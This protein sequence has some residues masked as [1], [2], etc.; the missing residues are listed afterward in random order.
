V[1]SKRVSLSHPVGYERAGFWIRFT[2]QWID[3]AIVI[4]LLTLVRRVLVCVDLYLPFELSFIL[5]L[6]LYNV[7]LVAWSGATLGKASCGLSVRQVDDEDLGFWRVLARETL[8]KF[9]SFAAL[10]LGYLWVGITRRKRSWHDILTSTAVFRHV[11][12]KKRGQRLTAAV[13]ALTTLALSVYV[14]QVAGIYILLKQMSHPKDSKLAY[15]EREPTNLTEVSSIEPEGQVEFLDWIASHGENPV[16]YAVM[17][18]REHQVVIF[19][20][21]HE[22]EAELRY[23]NDLV[24]QLV[25]RAGVT[26][27]AMEVCLAEDNELIEKLVTSPEF[28]RD[29]AMEIA[30]H[31]PWGLWGWKGYWD[32]FET[33]WQLNQRIKPPG[34]KVR[35][36]GLDMPMDMPALAMVG[37]EDNAGRDVPVWERLRIWRLLIAGPRVL[38]RDALFA[39]HVENEIIRKGHRGIVWVGRNHSSINSPQ[40]VSPQSL[41]PRMGF[42]LHSRHGEKIFQIRLHGHDIPISAVK[43]DFRGPEPE[44][45]EFLERI[46]E[47]CGE[48]PVGF[49]VEDSPFALLRDNGSFEYHFEPRLGLVDVASGYVFLAGRKDL[50]EC[51][52]MPGYLTQEMFIANKPFYK[53]FARRAGVTANNAQDFNDLFSQVGGHN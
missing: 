22:R 23:L 4:L 46:L 35:I 11:G 19:G 45:A 31:Q 21:S 32:I 34:E 42:M 3:I 33:V 7:V 2:A 38:S 41:F 18:A 15:M 9:I 5:L 12:C 29:L 10:S 6:I 17:K 37:L 48:M 47:K 40:I 25:Q 8:G 13:I 20:E 16:D 27:V 24:P 36:I 44:M 51:S 26:C 39:M 53:A 28:D 52:W 43:S 1:K 49:D 50:R 30:R 14:W